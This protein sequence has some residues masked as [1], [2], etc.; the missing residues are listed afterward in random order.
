VGAGVHTNFR[1][2]FLALFQPIPKEV[3]ERRSPEDLSKILEDY[4]QNQEF[5][6]FTP[7][8]LFITL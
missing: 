5:K 6:V 4:S 1:G 2:I 8:D 3:I 7:K